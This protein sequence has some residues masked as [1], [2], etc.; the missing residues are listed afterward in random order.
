M[1]G[2][3]YD[4]ATEEIKK[5]S[6]KY[7]TKL[8]EN[9]SFEVIYKGVLVAL[10]DGHTTYEFYTGVPDFGKLLFSNK[11]Y[12]LLAELSM[13]PIDKRGLVH[14][15]SVPICKTPSYK[16]VWSKVKVPT[17]GAGLCSTPAE[18]FSLVTLF[19]YTGQSIG[20]KDDYI[21]TDS[22]YK[23]LL[24]YLHT[25]PDGNYQVEMAEHNKVETFV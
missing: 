17:R 8:D 20:T 22:E 12:M 4:E 2:L 3:T 13:T 25:L 18:P 21:F 14:K 23:E 7:Q 6:S 19:N 16:V 15:W 11:L 5:L 24:D 1:N 9:Q 10:V